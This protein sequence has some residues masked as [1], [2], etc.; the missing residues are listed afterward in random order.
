MAPRFAY[1]AQKQKDEATLEHE[2][3]TAGDLITHGTFM[4]YDTPDKTVWITRNGDEMYRTTE[5]KNVDALLA[6]NQAAA[7]E[8]NRSGPL[9][10]TVQVASVPMAVHLK[11]AAEGIT[12]DP[13]A[14]ARRLN[15]GDYSKFRTNNLRV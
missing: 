6:A 15:D 12:D 11:W 13:V 4:L 7:N 2:Q 8:F 10:D 5:W 14:L 1:A 3:L 9:G